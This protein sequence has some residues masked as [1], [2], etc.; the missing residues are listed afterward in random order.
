MRKPPPDALIFSIHDMGSHTGEIKEYHREVPAPA[1]LST[2]M[3]GVP[4]GSELELDVRLESVGEGVLVSGTASFTLSGQCSRCLTEL[5]FPG[6]TDFQELFSYPER[7]AAEDTSRVTGEDID[8]E[9]LLRDQIVL[10]LPFTPLCRPDCAGLCPQCGA[11]L[12]DDPAHTH[13][14][15]ADPRWADLA[16]WRG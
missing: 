14:T 11:N 15:P 9:P 7:A 5:E 4:E 12:N 2:A 3:I 13:E 1:G 8:L 6:A 16:N 10:D